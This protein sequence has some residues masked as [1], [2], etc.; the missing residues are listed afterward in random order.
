ML[1][2]LLFHSYNQEQEVKLPIPDCYTQAIAYRNPQVR[3]EIRV[4]AALLFPVFRCRGFNM[5]DYQD[6]SS[7]V[8]FYRF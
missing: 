8:V 3:Y 4:A 6:I 2:L 5:S 1:V 7:V